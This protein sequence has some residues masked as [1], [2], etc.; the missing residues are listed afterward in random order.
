MKHIFGNC[1]NLVQASRISPNLCDVEKKELHVCKT[2]KGSYVNA[3]TSDINGIQRAIDLNL[4]PSGLTDVIVS[5]R[6]LHALAL[7]DIDSKARAFT[8]I[9][10]PIERA[11]STFYHLQKASLDGQYDAKYKE[12]TLLQYVQSDDT[13]SN[14]MVRWLT[15][16]QNQTMLTDDDLNFA[17]ELLRKKFII[18]LTEEMRLSFYRLTQYMNWSF[19]E[20]GRNCIDKNLSKVARQNKDL[21]PEI[22]VGSDEYKAIREKN[23]LDIEL[24]NYALELFSKQWKMIPEH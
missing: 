13:P 8:A 2:R 15:G 20:S 19:D 18:L 23:S 22:E 14:W 16:K 24:Y 11:V 9:R 12:M 21:Y 5:S 3:D 6:F 17:K 10:D 7:F 4:I 1:L